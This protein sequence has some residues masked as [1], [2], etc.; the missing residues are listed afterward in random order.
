MKQRRDK[1]F[2]KKEEGDKHTASIPRMLVTPEVKELIAQKASDCGL[3]ITQYMLGTALGRPVR[4]K[5]DA[6]IIYMLTRLTAQQRELFERGGGVYSEEYKQ[7][8]DAIVDAILAIA[9]GRV[10]E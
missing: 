3:S 7:L 8:L 4:S 6:T 1:L 10:G 2:V 5:T 9:E